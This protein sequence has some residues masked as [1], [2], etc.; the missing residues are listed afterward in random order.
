MSKNL[1]SMASERMSARAG[2]TVRPVQQTVPIAGL[3]LLAGLTIVWGCNWPVL[4]IALSQAPVWWFRSACVIIGGFGLLAIS[5]AGGARLTPKARDVPALLMC[6]VFAIVG[7][8]LFTGYGIAN[9]PAGRASIIAYTMPLWAAMYS[10]IILEERLTRDRM[11]GLALGLVGLGVLIGPDLVVFQT[12][13]IGSFFMLGAALSWALGTVLFKHFR[14]STSVG[15]TTGWML[16]IGAVP[17][18]LGAMALQP[19]PDLS[20]FRSEVWLALAYVFLLPMIFGQWAFYRIVHLFTPTV[21]AIGTMAVP[22]IGV[23]SSALIVGEPIG[24]RDLVSLVLICAALFSVL[25][26]PNLTSKR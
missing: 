3:L 18:T 20:A 12:A 25:V 16:L 21:A 11:A 17:I 1:R 7:W 24:G 22:V 14:W 19:F 23:I 2:R 6:S 4:K 26:L 9:M 8:H 13:P 5:A 15:V 10:V